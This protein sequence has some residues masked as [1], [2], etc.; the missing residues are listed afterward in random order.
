MDL[1]LDAPAKTLTLQD[2]KLLGQGRNGEVYDGGVVS[3]PRDLARGLGTSPHSGLAEDEAGLTARAERYGSNAFPEQAS[4]SFFELAVEA[5]QDFTVLTLI[6]AGTISLAL[7]LLVSGSTAPGAEPGGGSFVEGASILA[8]VAVVVAVGAGNNWQKE[9][10]FRALQA[11]QRDETVRCVR[12]GAERALGV[13]RLLPGDLL[14]VSAG[15]I[16]PVDGVLVGGNDLRLD[17]SALTGEAGEVLR[18]PE[19]APFLLSGSRVVRGSG[20]ML[21]TAVGGQ[22]AS[23]AIARAVMQRK[24]GG[25]G[26]DGGEL[27]EPTQLQQKL[28][29]YA[30]TIGKFGIAAALLSTSALIAR[31]SWMTFVVEAKPWDWVYAQDILDALI[32]G[33][34]IL[35]V[36]VPEGLP[37]AVTLSL[38]YSVK[39]MLAD[40]NLVRQL[41]ASETMGTATVI[42]SDKTGTLTQ[43]DMTLTG[44]WMGGREVGSLVEVHTLPTKSRPEQELQ[45]PGPVLETL[46]ESLEDHSVLQQ[47]GS[48]TELALMRLALQAGADPDAAR[49]ANRVLARVPFTY[50][51]KRS[52]VVV[53]LRAYTKGAPE[54][55]IGLCKWQLAPDGSQEPLDPHRLQ[56]FLDRCQHSGQR[57][58]ALGFR[59]VSVPSHTLTRL[60]YAS[61]AGSGSASSS[62]DE[63]DWR[64]DMAVAEDLEQDMVL[65]GVCAI[66]DPLRPEVP[67]AIAAAA[68]AGISVKMLTGD[69]VA[70]AAAI[71]RQAGILPRDAPAT[72]GLH[73]VG[74]R[75]FE[76]EPAAAG[77]T[78]ALLPDTVMEGEEFRSRILSPSGA[79]IEDEFLKIWPRLR[80]LAR[81][82]PADKHA[83]V[84]GV[85]Q[86]TDDIVAVTGDG[87]ND[88]PA[89]R[90]AHVGFAMNQGTSIAKEA[91]DIV[92]LDNNFASI[93][94]AALW[95][96]NVYASV[97]RFLQFQLTTNVVAVVTAVAGSL[98][99]ARSPV[100]AVQM[101]WVNLLM[102]SLAGLALATEPPSPKLLDL[103]PFDKDHQFLAPGSTSLRNVVGQST[104]QL[105]VMALL[106]FAAPGLLGI[107]PGNSYPAHT[108]STHY[109]IV[110]NSFVWMQ[111]FNQFNSRMTLNSSRLWDGLSKARLFCIILATEAVLQF[112]GQVFQTQPLEPKYWA[113][114][115]GIGALSLLVHEALRTEE[116][117]GQ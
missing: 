21:V 79:I 117:E 31:F 37:L 87:T 40:H 50:T 8:S 66:E 67:G 41:Q 34:T 100:T 74:V 68:R 71:A 20:R 55:V 11:L 57:M 49:R 106:V 46:L 5:L 77:G 45:P 1:D 92:L 103:K 22:S 13:Q 107:D 112:G 12:C 6:G 53:P 47:S 48:S 105:C 69:N 7:S 10:Q 59:D 23:G 82:T 115:L 56:G 43:N 38:A 27:R 16:L 52:L 76:T 24:G 18:D 36:A 44:L 97:T 42:C 113:M 4:V 96:R 14:L 91:A 90:A 78:T 101:L 88:A 9:R 60:R 17:Q 86:F 114:S 95:G 104:F 65:L 84:M 28:E 33:I 72:H 75:E 99:T 85:R 29:V 64:L 89:L 108:P 62:G 61:A 81:C 3:S 54:I 109:T 26:G 111:L 58:V 25:G 110:F 51:R 19:H 30:T 83:I 80:V 70:T 93:I 35:V 63:E 73:V 2:L 116:S 32:I 98:A 94:S 15:D 102:D 39:Q